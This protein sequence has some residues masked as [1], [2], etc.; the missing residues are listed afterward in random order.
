[1]RTLRWLLLALVIQVGIWMALWMHVQAWDDRFREWWMNED[2]TALYVDRS[3]YWYEPV[4]NQYLRFDL[5]QRSWQWVSRRTML[6]ENAEVPH[7]Q[8]IWEL[9]GPTGDK[10]Y[11]AELFDRHTHQTL[12]SR[13][14]ER[15]RDLPAFH[16]RP[17]LHANR[18]LVNVIGSRVD[19]LDLDR[20]DSKFESLVFATGAGGS[21]QPIPTPYDQMQLLIETVPE[22]GAGAPPTHVDLFQFLENGRLEHVRSWQTER[23]GMTAVWRELLVTMPLGTGQVEVRSLRTDEL[24]E[25][26]DCP[27][28]FDPAAGCHFAWTPDGPVLWY[29]T[30]L[31]TMQWDPVRGRT[32]PAHPAAQL[33]D[34]HFGSLANGSLQIYQLPSGIEVWYP[35]LQKALFH[36]PN[37]YRRRESLL[38]RD[39]LLTTT[40]ACGISF[41]FYD[42]R[43]GRCTDCYRPFSYVPWLCLVLLIAYILWSYGWMRASAEAGWAPWLDCLLV[44]GLPCCACLMF[45]SE[46]M[47]RDSGFNCL[48]DYGLGLATGALTMA[49]CWAMASRAPMW[50]RCLP[51]VLLEIVCLILVRGVPEDKNLKLQYIL[52]LQQFPL[53]C[54]MLTLQTMRMFTSRLNVAGGEEPEP[55]SDR[56]KLH[57]YFM[58]TLC[59]AMTLW[60]YQLA[61]AATPG[62]M[63]LSALIASLL[64]G[65]L[66]W[67]MLKAGLARSSAMFAIGG[68]LAGGL[69]IALLTESMLRWTMDWN[70]EQLVKNSEA[71]RVGLTSTAAAF[72]SCLPF[73]WRGVRG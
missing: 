63:K 52:W 69:V 46:R 22:G 21:S 36:L 12:K 20:P 59:V 48:S 49:V 30:K 67:S 60:L 2:R 50:Q 62:R 15:L 18:F 47:S 27:P 68:W 8:E 41:Y 65:L 58:L 61:D 55:G 34:L 42:V 13:E 29:N 38:D 53:C 25:R 43:T 32:Q 40:G 37:Q 51:L 19:Y 24:S 64:L 44:L 17:Q 31:G 26:R 70:V 5:K 23:P 56:P 39:T 71:I 16:F 28:S 33:T 10:S 54:L 73:R 14:V 57:D 9:K 45:A 7:A 66:L 72:V 11:R 3:L 1:M 35:E 6:V 4:C